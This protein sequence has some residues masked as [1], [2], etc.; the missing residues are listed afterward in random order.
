MMDA[1]FLKPVSMKRVLLL[2]AWLLGAAVSLQAQT[3]RELIAENP[4][5]AAGNL[6]A[7]EPLDTL[8]SPPPAGYRP[9]Y[10][11]HFGRHGSRYHTAESQFSAIALLEKYGE[12]G[13]LTD[14]GEQVLGD[15]RRI[16]E[17]TGGAF[18]ALTERGARE[19]HQIARRMQSHYPEVFSDPERGA[20]FAFATHSQ[21]VIDSRD[22]FVSELI[23]RA[24]DLRV[25]SLTEDDKSATED[26][27]QEVRGYSAD[28]DER[29][30]LSTVSTKAARKHWSDSL[31]RTRILQE[32]F[33]DPARVSSSVVSSVY[34]AGRIRQAMT[35]EDLPWIE[36]YFLPSEL[37]YLWCDGDISWYDKGCVTP[38]NK[39]I[40]VRKSG[41]GILEMI[42]R[43]ADRAIREGGVAAHLRFSHDTKLMPLLAAMGL[44]GA[45]FQGDPVLAPEKIFSFQNIPLG[46]NVQLI[47]YRN[48]DG[49]VL[50]K[51]L[52]NEKETTIPSLRTCTGPYYR[53]DTLKAFFTAQMN[54]QP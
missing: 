35:G 5:R 54:R 45:D 23:S 44:E 43:D 24:P 26:A 39:G 15:L 7:Y 37:F 1:G 42:L 10:I 32:W 8:F 9:F 16:Y 20:V 28:K 49:D 31:D 12:D 2:L 18:G 50:V 17:A 48:A 22:A 36:K 25:Q 41:G 11:S 46:G 21:R 30:Y 29:Q 4:L 19:H 40:I 51:I 34:N 47:F 38:E 6:H 13:L 53:W 3:A 14:K 33:T 27:R 52:K